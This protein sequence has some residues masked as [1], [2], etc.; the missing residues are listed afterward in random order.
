M[1]GLRVFFIVIISI[2][3]VFLISFVTFAFTAKQSVEG[4]ILKEAIKETLKKEMNEVTQEQ[5][6]EIEKVLDYEGT[7]DVIDSILDEYVKYMDEESTEVSNETVEYVFDFIKEHKSDIEKITGEEIDIS[8]I[9]T[10]ENR[11]EFKKT[12]DKGFNKIKEQ[13][14]SEVNWTIKT[15]AKITS[16]KFLI[17]M[18]YIIGG[19]IVLIGLLSFSTYKWMLPVGI[20]FIVSGVLTGILF[21]ISFFTSTILKVATDVGLGV[22][23]KFLLICFLSELVGGIILVVVQNKLNKKFESKEK[24]QALN[25]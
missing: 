22:N 9:D 20:V 23:N 10:V 1:K 21:L 25:N 13:G 6:D 12:L 16:K 3:L 5:M 14:N 7:D 8:K 17:K 19:L 4:P 18:L 2:I 15:Y 24:E 11:E